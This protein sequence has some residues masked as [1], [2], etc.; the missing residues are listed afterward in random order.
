MESV[1]PH[2]LHLKSCSWAGALV[3]VALSRVAAQDG[4]V[5]FINVDAAVAKPEPALATV[6]K[7]ARKKVSKAKRPAAPICYPSLYP[8]PLAFNMTWFPITDRTFAEFRALA[9]RQLA[10][11]RRP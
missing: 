2:F 6:D 9:N 1:N 5:L 7:P 11:A 4:D 10:K 3:L 8:N